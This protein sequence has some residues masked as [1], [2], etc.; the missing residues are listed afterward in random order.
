LIF[1]GG[2][3]LGASYVLGATSSMNLT[4]AQDTY[5]ESTY[6]TDLKETIV[7]LGYGKSF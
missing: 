4:V 1:K 3:N 7:A 5:Q 6:G 2:T